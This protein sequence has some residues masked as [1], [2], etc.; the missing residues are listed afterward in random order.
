[1]KAPGIAR[2][3]APTRRR[4]A[5]DTRTALTRRET[6]FS[7]AVIAAARQVAAAA[8]GVLL[9]AACSSSVS[10]ASPAPTAVTPTP[11]PTPTPAPAAGPVRVTI[12]S[13]G[14][15][16]AEVT[17]DAGAQVTFINNDTQPHDVAGGPDLEHPDCREIDAVGFLSP[18]QSR[19]TAPLPTVRTCDY[20][21]HSNHSPVFNGR[22]IIR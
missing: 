6:P 14:V 1:M 16:P 11:T 9:F 10:P 21:D 12:T 15:N 5:D 7:R 4:P 8:A 22:I 2:Q 19:Q 13:A 17:I 20:H 3:S 18:G